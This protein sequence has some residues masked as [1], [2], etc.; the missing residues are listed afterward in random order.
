MCVRPAC[1]IP[2]HEPTP[3]EHAARL[4]ARRHLASVAEIGALATLLYALLIWSSVL[5]PA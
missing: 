4:I 1:H 3:R 2:S 5:S